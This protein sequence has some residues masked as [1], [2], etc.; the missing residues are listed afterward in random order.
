LTLLSSANDIPLLKEVSISIPVGTRVLI[1][2]PAQAARIALFRATAG[3]SFKGSGRI[4]HPG[5]DDILFL[6]QRPY[7]PTGTLRQVLV[8]NERAGE[9]SDE[10]IIQLLS[11]LHLEQVVEQA[12]GLD[13]EKNWEMLLSLQEQ[14]LLILI[15]ILLAEPRF[16]F[17]DR[18]DTTLGLKQ[19]HR[20]MQMLSESSI[21]VINNAETD[22]LRD[23]HDAVLECSEDGGWTWT[24]NRA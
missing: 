3:I 11:E 5:P 21:T 8:R 10:S 12:S 2:G 22:I 13:A 7:L 20:I 18:A 9:I 6:P 17:L 1:T 15:S 14:Q 19:L 24:E 4:I 23:C 16:A